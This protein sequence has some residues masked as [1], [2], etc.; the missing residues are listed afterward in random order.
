MLSLKGVFRGGEGIGGT[1]E[2][3]RAAI[4]D[5]QRISQDYCLDL[6]IDSPGVTG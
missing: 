3:G 6:A 2:V 1:W 5:R 4:E